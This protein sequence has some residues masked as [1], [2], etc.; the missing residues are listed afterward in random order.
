[1]SAADVAMMR[2]QQHTGQFTRQVV[3]FQLQSSRV[4]RAVASE[5]QLQEVMTDIWRITS[6]SRGEGAPEP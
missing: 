3:T 6:T 1:M 2:Q 5:R 4:A